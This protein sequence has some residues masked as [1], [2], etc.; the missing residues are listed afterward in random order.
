MQVT[1]HFIEAIKHKDKGVLIWEL[2]FW[3]ERFPGRMERQFIREE[4]PIQKVEQT[5]EEEDIPVIAD[6]EVLRK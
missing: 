3:N 6:V 1:R 2:V 5:T 4:A